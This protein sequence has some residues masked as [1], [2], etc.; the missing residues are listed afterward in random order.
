MLVNLG[1]L[2]ENKIIQKSSLKKNINN[3]LPNSPKEFL[4]STR[5]EFNFVKNFIKTYPFN[6]YAENSQVSK[7][8]D[9]N[10]VWIVIPIN[11]KA[12]DNPT[13]C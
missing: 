6:E 9:S 8:I 13:H 1:L 2:I 5:T 7:I 12:L 3:M 11:S 4:D 10:N